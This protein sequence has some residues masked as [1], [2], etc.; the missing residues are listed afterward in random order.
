M[1]S[2]QMHILAL[3]FSGGAILY[4]VLQN[5]KAMNSQFWAVLLGISSA[6]LGFLFI[7][8]QD[9]TLSNDAIRIRFF[10]ISLFFGTLGLWLGGSSVFADI[11]NRKLNEV[12]FRAITIFLPILTLGLFAQRPPAAST[13]P[14]SIMRNQPSQN[15]MKKTALESNTLV[16]KTI[17][18]TLRTKEGPKYTS[19][20]FGYA[21]TYQNEWKEWDKTDFE[22]NPSVEFGLKTNSGLSFFVV[23]VY[24]MAQQPEASNLFEAMLHAGKLSLPYNY[25]YKL[26]GDPDF[27]YELQPQ[28]NGIQ[29]LEKDRRLYRIRF[30]QGASM[31]YLWVTSMPA[32]IS[33]DDDRQGLYSQLEDV[34]PQFEIFHVAPPNPFQFEPEEMARH[35]VVFKEIIGRNHDLYLEIGRT[36][37][38]ERKRRSDSESE[39]SEVE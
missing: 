13:Q 7:V 11:K 15:S 29:G 3:V 1:N 10:V 31:A 19:M 32:A 14:D 26:N 20:K 21:V 17:E 38:I 25:K 6:F 27:G 4:T 39:T 5:R 16:I 30:A 24:L 33:G 22:Q 28:E 37:M 8:L 12:P 36:F 2:P 18:K 9:Q 34:E 23:P 35:A